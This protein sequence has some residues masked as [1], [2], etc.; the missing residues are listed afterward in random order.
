[1]MPKIGDVSA[2]KTVPVDQ[3]CQAMIP[4]ATAISN[5]TMEPTVSGLRQP[6]GGSSWA[7]PYHPAAK[8]PKMAPV[9]AASRTNWVVTILSFRIA[10]HA[11]PGI[12]HRH[13][14]AG[15]G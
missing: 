6:A 14:P 1:M 3:F 10:H 2:S 4:P 9:I 8:K 12:L 15:A 5:P 13:A 7:Q 11:T